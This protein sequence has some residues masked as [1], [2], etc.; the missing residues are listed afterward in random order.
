MADLS[1]TIGSVRLPNPVIPA[2]GTFGIG[3]ARV[4][5]ISRLGALVPKTVMPEA[6]TGH[7]P[8]RLTEAAGGLINAIGIPSVGIEAFLAD[9]LPAYRAFG[10]PIVVSVSADTAEAFAM[11]CAAMAD[12]GIAAIEL[13]LSCPNL[14][15]GGR[16]FALDPGPAADVVRACRAAT[17][18]PLWCKLSPNSGIPGQVAEAIEANGGDALIVANTMLAIAFDKE[19]NPRLANRTGGMSGLPLKPINLRLTDEIARR[20]ALPI[21]GCGGVAT[22]QDALDY[23]AAGASA[24]AIGTAT[25]SRPTTM[26]HLIDAL[27]AH[28]TERGLAAQDLVRRRTT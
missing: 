19:G 3:H 9:V 27:D 15:A 8:P 11:M 18:L 24:V 1:V 2:S 14:E 6:R 16:A 22:L 10:A 17:G 4:M 20:V 21:I 5:D 13:N 25:L 26:V 7:P 23:F 28:L 12:T